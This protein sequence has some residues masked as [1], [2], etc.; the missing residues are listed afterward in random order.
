MTAD[1]GI[2]GKGTAV[3]MAGVLA[4]GLAGAVSAQPAEAASYKPSKGKVT[5]V[6]A[7]KSSV[8]AYA[9][10]AKR[11]KGYQF[12]LYVEKGSKYRPVKSKSVKGTSAS[13]RKYAFKKLKAGKYRVKVRA[14]T[15]RHH[16]K[17]YGK[18][19][20]YRYAT[21]RAAA[22]V[23]AADRTEGSTANRKD[24]GKQAAHEHSWVYHG[25]VYENVHHDA[26]YR[27]VIIDC[28]YYTYPKKKNDEWVIYSI[29]PANGTE[30]QFEDALT[31][32]PATTT[33][34][35][36]ENRDDGVE[37]KVTVL[38]P[39]NEYYSNGEWHNEI[40]DAE[41]KYLAETDNIMA[42]QSISGT[43]ETTKQELVQDAYDDQKLVKD[44]YWEC[45]GCGA[46]SETDPDED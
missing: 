3:A 37:R 5:K 27:N 11:A 41:D 22:K 1:T 17:A 24:P 45:S 46:V 39:F 15:Y 2:M 29:S 42:S 4:L 38:N 12:R 19:S 16:K 20:A 34:N 23:K 9:K 36:A 26:E 28:M 35:I 21:V 33:W 32:I 44:G 13:M 6:V 14:Y 30:E 40:T 7:G 31:C 25:P 8:K 18:W 43:I 10:K